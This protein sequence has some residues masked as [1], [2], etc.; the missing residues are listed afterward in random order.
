MVITKVPEARRSRKSR[1]EPYRRLWGG[2]HPCAGGFEYL[3]R[4]PASRRRRRKGKSQIW[5]SKMWSRVPRDSDPRKTTLVRASSDCKWQSCPL[6]RETAPYQQTRNCL[7]VMKIWSWD[8]DGCIIPRQTGRL[9]VGRNIRLRLTLKYQVMTTDLL[10][11]TVT[12]ANDRFV[13]ASERAP[14]IKKPATVR[15]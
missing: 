15:Q 4:D 5:D 11:L 10:M 13:L 9:T 7:T 12:L 3:N 6:I 2:V 1:I 14:H 8:P